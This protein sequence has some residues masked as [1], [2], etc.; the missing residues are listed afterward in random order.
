M[1]PEGEGSLHSS[2]HSAPVFSALGTADKLTALFIPHDSHS[3]MH[4]WV[5]LSQ[6]VL[7][8]LGH[9]QRE[10]GEGPWMGGDRAQCVPGHSALNSLWVQVY[11]VTLSHS[12]L[13]QIPDYT[14][15]FSKFTACEMG[16]KVLS[17]GARGG[18][19]LI[20]RRPQHGPGLQGRS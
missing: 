11:W 12:P 16:T 5:P 15:G 7:S 13:H 2:L 3:Y 1:T 9:P 20:C 19:M 4:L 14:Q 6:G 8:G 18:E 10:G 17:D